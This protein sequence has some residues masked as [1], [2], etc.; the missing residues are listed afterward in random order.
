MSQ[1]VTRKVVF[2]S[3]ASGEHPIELGNN[4][5]EVVISSGEN[6]VIELDSRKNQAREIVFNVHGDQDREASSTL[7]TTTTRKI[8]R[9]YVTE[10]G[11]HKE[12]TVQTDP[13]VTTTIKHENRRQRLLKTA[14][15]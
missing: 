1:V 7:T 4:N 12:F 5:G 11:E 3:T 10:A 8:I 13:V 9:T 2:Y 6:N 15:T 14:W